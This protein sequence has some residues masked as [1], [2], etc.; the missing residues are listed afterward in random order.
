MSTTLACPR[1]GSYTCP[2]TCW[3]TDTTRTDFKALSLAFA[4][5][6]AKY[7]RLLENVRHIHAMA[8]EK[9]PDDASV[10]SLLACVWHEL[11]ATIQETEATR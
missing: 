5:L 10:R 7:Q 4:A 8:S 1:C 9:T 2:G 3:P 11:G 6:L